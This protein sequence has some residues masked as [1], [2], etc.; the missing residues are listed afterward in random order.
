MNNKTFITSITLVVSFLLYLRFGSLAFWVIAVTGFF[1]AL[2]IMLLETFLHILLQED[3]FQKYRRLKRKYL[4]VSFFDVDNSD[5]CNKFSIR[6][7]DYFA[8]MLLFFVGAIFLI[9]III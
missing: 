4:R 7:I 6:E 9:Y 3:S 2:F 5:I 8:I 1:S